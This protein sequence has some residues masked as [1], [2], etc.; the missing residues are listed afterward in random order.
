MKLCDEFVNL[1]EFS[2]FGYELVEIVFCMLCVML[3][4]A[5]VFMLVL[6]ILD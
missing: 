2:S 5:Y 3:V 4:N 6:E 1:L